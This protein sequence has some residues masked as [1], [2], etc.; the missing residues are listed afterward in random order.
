L[1][2]RDKGYLPGGHESNDNQGEEEAPALEFIFGK[3]IGGGDHDEYLEAD[4]GNNDGDGIPQINGKRY[5]VPG[6]GHILELGHLGDKGGGEGV[7]FLLCLE[8]H[9][10]H[11]EKGKHENTDDNNLDANIQNLE[12]HL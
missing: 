10:D 8:G 3:G 4:N 1:V 9:G 5:P 12:N 2:N 6:F 7:D 11:P